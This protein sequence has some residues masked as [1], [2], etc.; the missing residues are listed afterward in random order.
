M[1]KPARVASEITMN[2]LHHVVL[3]IPELGGG[4]YHIMMFTLWWFNIAIEYS[5]FIVD[6]P[7]KDG[8]FP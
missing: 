4:E 2:W 3:S 6:L 8:D 1:F 5:T 7:S